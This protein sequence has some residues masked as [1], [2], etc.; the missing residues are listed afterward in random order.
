MPSLKLAC[1]A[2]MKSF[3]SI[4]I[5]RL[6]SL[7]GGMVASP[8]PTVPISSD[9]M[10]S[11]EYGMPIDMRPNEAAV[12]QPAVPPPTITIFRTLRCIGTSG[13]R[14]RGGRSHAADEIQVGR[15]RG[16][17]L[18]HVLAQRRDFLRGLPRE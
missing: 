1:V 4:F 7:I 6:K 3:S 15:H 2:R 18:L 12:I 11:I 17:E 10:S 13:G 8:T 9:S 5:E 14:A 16:R